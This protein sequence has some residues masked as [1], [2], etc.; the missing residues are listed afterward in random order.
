MTYSSESWKSAGHL[1]VILTLRAWIAVISLTRLLLYD[2]PNSVDLVF[3][4]R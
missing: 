4:M 2:G 3:R 1:A